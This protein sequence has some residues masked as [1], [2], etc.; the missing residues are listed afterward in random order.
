MFILKDGTIAEA[1]TDN[2][3]HPHALST[4][5]YD[6][7]TTWFG[8]CES[9]TTLDAYAGIMRT[10]NLSS[11]GTNNEIDREKLDKI[12]QDIRDGKLAK[13]AGW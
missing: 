9:A 3:A 13:L 12:K 2:P 4:T 10:I 6:E 8:L 5:E 11:L 7:E 1:F